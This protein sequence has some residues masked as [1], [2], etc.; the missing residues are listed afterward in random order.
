VPD[1]GAEGHG[2]AELQENPFLEEADKQ[3]G[4]GREEVPTASSAPP[5]TNEAQLTTSADRLEREFEQELDQLE[6]R[7]DRASGTRPRA[8]GGEDGD[9]RLEAL[10]NTPD[11]GTSLP[12]HVLEQAR[13]QEASPELLRV[14][15]HIAYSLDEDGRLV[16]T[17][18][19]IAQFLLVPIPSPRPRSRWSAGWTR[20]A[21]A[22][23][24]CATAS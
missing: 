6:S 15:E 17:A 22:R 24:T 14:I 23:A 2:R 12:E 4:T 1:A 19:Q 20:P 3:D 7:T 11:P 16:D 10:Y 18:E 8:E 9:R 21:S 5:E 13:M